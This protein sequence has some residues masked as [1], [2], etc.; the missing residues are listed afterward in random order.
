MH[1]DE[2]DSSNLAEDL[3]RT[4]QFYI[5]KNAPMNPGDVPILLYH[6][7]IKDMYT[8]VFLYEKQLLELQKLFEREIKSTGKVY[9][10][11][12]T[13]ILNKQALLDAVE[14]IKNKRSY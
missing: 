14:I 6:D 2:I 5:S 3:I 12:T 7:D 8:L 11:K 1:Q 4:Q 10:V 9:G 13:G